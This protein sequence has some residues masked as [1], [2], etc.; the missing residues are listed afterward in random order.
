M[1]EPQL[2]TIITI[3]LD[4]I[5]GLKNTAL[6]I[7]GQTNQDLEWI[8]IDGGSGDGTPSWLKDTNAKWTSEPDN[9]I[10]DAMNKG[11]QRATG[12]YLLFLNAGDALAGPDTLAEL[13]ASIYECSITPDFIYGD[14]LETKTVILSEREGSRN[15]QVDSSPA[16][17]NDNPELHYKPARPY[18]K[19]SRGMF[20]HHQAMLYRRE[21]LADMR[22]D[23]RYKIAADYDLT[24]RFIKDTNKVLYLPSPICIFESGGV[25]QQQVRLGRKEQLQIRRENN[26][27]GPLINA[28]I[29]AAQSLAWQ[30]RQTMPN[31][32]WKIKSRGG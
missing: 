21:A 24:V 32:Y 26:L 6:S 18:S 4:N 28:G 14:A 27:S 23:E 10:Y 7:Y 19:I 1:T 13:A 16:A 3:T 9:G 22:Y 5:S 31:L 25:S 20:T 30:A 17:Q 8:V 2:F 12:K 15:N 11:I 29:F